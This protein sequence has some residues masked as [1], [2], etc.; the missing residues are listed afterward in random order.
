MFCKV[1]SINTSSIFL[2]TL[3]I[4]LIFGIIP[5]SV[6][7]EKSIEKVMKKH[8]E[9]VCDLAKKGDIERLV[10]RMFI[11]KRDMG[12]YLYQGIDEKWSM[13][14]H[15]DNVIKEL[16]EKNPNIKLSKEDIRNFKAYIYS[17]NKRLP[18]DFSLDGNNDN[19]YRPRSNWGISPSVDIGITICLCGAFLYC[20]PVPG[21]QVAGGLLMTFG[22]EKVVSAIIQKKEDDFKEEQELKKR[23]E[24]QCS[25]CPKKCRDCRFCRRRNNL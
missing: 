5:N 13:N 7:A 22:G 8:A 10:M 12:N 4:T 23:G 20:I 17:L 19:D 9:I 6:C 25:Q 16:C 2:F 11:M 24:R 1:R 3:F 15:I 18:T 14:E 21:C